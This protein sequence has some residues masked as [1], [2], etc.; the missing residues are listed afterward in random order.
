M[1]TL[2]NPII[3]LPTDNNCQ[4]DEPLCL[5]GIYFME[6]KKEIWK[7]IPGYE[8]LYQVSNHGRIK[9]LAKTVNSGRGG[10]KYVAESITIG[11][12]GTNGYYMKGLYKNKR[13]TTFCIHQL[14][15]LSFLGYKSNR[16]FVVDHINENKLDNRLV[17]LQI[18]SN[19]LNVE[20]GKRHTKTSKYKSVC[21][22]K[23]RNKWVAYYQKKGFKKTIGRFDCEQK[24]HYAVQLFLNKL[25][26][27]NKFAFVI[28]EE[29]KKLLTERILEAEILLNS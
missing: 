17:N 6:I 5:M 14:V 2:I 1:K 25:K 28:P 27:I 13:N 3:T 9:I 29:D 11:S 7:D 20:K 8:N 19:T 4:T 21:F 16:K 26:N 15:V 24:A 23:S 22:D 12:I 10:V 18:I